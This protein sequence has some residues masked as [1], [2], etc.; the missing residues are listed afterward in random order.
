ME[1]YYKV[2]KELQA[3]LPAEPPK[4]KPVWYAYKNGQLQ[5]SSTISRED[6]EKRFETR[7][8]EKSVSNQTQ[9]DWYWK[10]RREIEDAAFDVWY[11]E[12][13]AQYNY[14]P[15][16]VFELCYAEAYDRGHSSGYDEV[17]NCM[18]DAAEF[19]IKIL[20]SVKP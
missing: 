6:A 5:G 8:V 1:S 12:L 14:L 13:K 3:D 2:L 7:V 16:R 15:A 19:A 18:S 17:A 20:G 11:S 4:A 9:I 10:E